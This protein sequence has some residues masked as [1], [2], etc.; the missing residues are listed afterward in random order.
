MRWYILC[1][2]MARLILLGQSIKISFSRG[3]MPAKENGIVSFIIIRN[4]R[5]DKDL[6]KFQDLEAGKQ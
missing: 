6:T 3:I 4:I 1:N 2:A 5:F